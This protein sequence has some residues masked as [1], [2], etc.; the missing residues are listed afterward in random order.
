MRILRL[1]SGPLEVIVDYLKIKKSQSD[2][3]SGTQ[4]C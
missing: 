2:R 1:V 4:R 3:L